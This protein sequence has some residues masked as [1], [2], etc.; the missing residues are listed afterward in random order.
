MVILAAD[1][2]LM[3]IQR[4]IIM[5]IPHK[6]V[7]PGKPLYTGIQIVSCTI[8]F[9]FFACRSFRPKSSSRCVRQPT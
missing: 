3:N 5:Q 4:G 6:P 2:D 7:G 1:K 9:M 8:A